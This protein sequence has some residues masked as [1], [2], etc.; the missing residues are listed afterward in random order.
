MRRIHAFTLIELLV[1]ISII[2][3]LI[4][5]LLPALQVAREAARATQCLSN[6][7]QAGIALALYAQDYDG[8][9][10]RNANNWRGPL[11]ENNYFTDPRGL[12]CPSWEAGSGTYGI[13]IE[14]FQGGVSWVNVS[15][16]GTMAR[17]QV[18]ILNLYELENVHPPSKLLLISDTAAYNSGPEEQSSIWQPG[19]NNPTRRFISHLRHAGSAN[20]MALD[21]SARALRDDRLEENNVN[22]WIGFD[23]MR[24]FKGGM[25]P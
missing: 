17:D 8:Q 16:P 18:H 4:A 1:V 2:A 14:F 10:R 15:P 20:F 25:S 13:R 3:L 7:R 5:L 6:Q 24:Y 21:G 12:A 11:V 22:L 19:N 9:V 23:G